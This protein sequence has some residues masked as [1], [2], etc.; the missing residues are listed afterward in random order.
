MTDDGALSADSEKALAAAIAHREAGEYEAA[1][2]L[3]REIVERGDADAATFAHFAHSLSLAG[4]EEAARE[5]LGKALALDPKQP[6]A[7]R[8]S[9]RQLLQ[10]GD[11]AAAHAAAEAALA[12]APADPLNKLAL[13]ATLEGGP[14]NERA[15]A[16]VEEVVAE[17]PDLAEGYFSRASLRLRQGRTQDADADLNKALALKPHLATGW[18][19][20]AELRRRARDLPGCLAALEKYLALAPKDAAARY[21]LGV[22]KLSAG[23]PAGAE[24]AFRLANEPKPVP[25]ALEGLGAAL[26]AQDKAAEAEEPFSAWATLEPQNPKPLLGLTAALLR[27]RRFDD[28]EQA[29]AKALALEPGSADANNKRGLALGELGR[30]LEAE[31]HFERAVQ[32]D[33]AFTDAHYNLVGAQLLLGRGEQA[34]AHL[35]KAPPAIQESPALLTIYANALSAVGRS[36]DAAAALR[37]LIAAQPGN[38]VAHRLLAAETRYEPDTPHLAE[39]RRVAERGDLDQGDRLDLDFALGKA[40][41]DVG[42]YEQAFAHLKAA[43]AAMR[44]T[45][46]YDSHQD[47]T[48]TTVILDYFGKSG[49]AEHAVKAPVEPRPIFLIGMPRSGT[50][51]VEQILASHPQ[52]YGAGEVEELGRLVHRR[53]FDSTG[54]SASDGGPTE[55][56]R[57]ISDGYADVL[58]KL[59]QESP[60]ATDRNIGNYRYV[61]FIKMAFPNAVI[62]EIDRDPRAT[63]ASIYKNRFSAGGVGFA[64]DV[65]EIISKYQDYVETMRFWRRM[66]PDA[67]HRLRYEDLIADQEGQTRRLLTQCELEWDEA[68]L[69]F[70]ESRRTVVTRSKTQVRQPINTGSVSA[71]K[72]FEPWLGD[73]FARLAALDERGEEPS[74]SHTAPKTVH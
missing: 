67:I 24:A 40:L 64:Y 5:A 50:T 20:L 48:Q 73:A 41:E 23:E 54:A 72:R 18:R 1:E 51:L 59:A 35:E 53:F 28:A 11:R 12:G 4:R 52:V 7:L 47:R 55:L 44:K 71:W 17:A 33:P 2:A 8:N 58:R 6:V 66:F 69:K 42:E 9:A 34:V 27:L 57:S 16:L 31:Q 60:A 38:G 39:M 68:C 74:A 15:Q 61:G 30:S 36:Q 3:F 13:A 62:V 19:L 43:N 25:P 26:L 14:E 10:A 46:R 22:A 70:Y 63:F 21:M 56:F 49:L 32:S 29:A 65:Q 45:L 37:R